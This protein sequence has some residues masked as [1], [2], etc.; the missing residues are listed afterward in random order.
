MIAKVQQY[1]DQHRSE[2]LEFLIALLEADTTNVQHG[3]YGNE[4]NGQTIVKE[5]MQ[6]IGLEIDVFEPDNERL[7]TYREFNPGHHYKSRANV[8]GIWR[9]SGGGK[10]IIL[11]GHID[12]MPAEHTKEWITPPLK[13]IVQ[14]GRL[15][16]RGSCDMKAGLAANIIA[17]EALKA[18]GVSL[19]GDIIVQSVVDEEGGGNG[20]LACID[21]GYRADGAI[22]SEPTELNVLPA[23][24][25]FVIYRL[26]LKGRATHSALKWNG[27]NAIEK[28]MKIML[29]LQ[30]LER[31]WTIRHRHPL[32][33]PPTIC[34]GTIQGGA[35]GTIVPDECTLQFSVHYLPKSGLPD[36]M[37]EDVKAELEA[38]IAAAAQA[39]SWLR[40]H[41]PKLEIYQEG[42]G[43]E[44][45]VSHPLVTLLAEKREATVG[46]KP[47]IKG[48]ESGC[49]AR[50]LT[51]YGDTPSVIFGPGNLSNAHGV[52]E[53]VEIEQFHQ[54]AAT[55]AAT[56][57][58]WCGRD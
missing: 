32:L 40:E 17:V 54:C 44:I 2:H 33:P 57:L 18:A 34:F 27:V 50:L 37:G 14:D 19:K 45:A 53:Y 21:R 7:Q 3:V 23:H 24:M 26:S 29:A 56:L 49:D 10:S 13:P 11:N 48:L 9:G 39:D 51:N 30:E 25:G 43:Y 15:Y 20:T 8:V 31:E 36:Y 16:A 55:I 28:M 42:S 35:A 4:Q 46:E 1:L 5:R 6:Q 22:F 47:I 58:E 41:A 12:T 38:V 52:N